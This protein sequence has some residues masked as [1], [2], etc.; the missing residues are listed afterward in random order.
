M[1]G[2]PSSTTPSAGTWSPWASSTTSSRTT[3][4]TG[5]WRF[6]PAR[7]THTSFAV[8]IDSLSTLRFAR[9]SWKTPMTR[10][11][12]TTT[13]KATFLYDPVDTTRAAIATFTALNSVNVCSHRICHTD[14]VFTSAFAFTWPARTRS[15]TCSSVRPNAARPP[16]PRYVP[17]SPRPKK[18]LRRS[19]SPRRP[20]RMPSS[21][22]PQ[23]TRFQNAS[24]LP[25]RHS[26]E[27]VVT[28][29]SGPIAQWIRAF[30]SGAKGRG[31]EPHWGHHRVT[32]D[33]FG[34]P[35]FVTL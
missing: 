15:A 25:V 3:S 34:R 18:H 29:L 6:S 12:A 17:P 5:T 4:D 23:S 32:R 13:I 1:R 28:S 31:F 8:R 24:A 14:F 20:P 19:R 11:L 35:F 27:L 33:A 22:S 2:E 16:S 7:S 10:L 30:A 21:Q 9:I 26:A